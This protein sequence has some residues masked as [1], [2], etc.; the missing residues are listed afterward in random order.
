MSRRALS[1]LVTLMLAL[2][3]AAAAASFVSYGNDQIYIGAS[4]YPYEVGAD[5]R[6]IPVRI[7]ASIYRD[8]ENFYFAQESGYSEMTLKFAYQTQRGT[9]ASS[10]VAQVL[11]EP[12]YCNYD[13]VI[14]Y[15]DASRP[16]AVMAFNPQTMRKTVAYRSSYDI[17]A[18]VNSV[19]GLLVG[20]DGDFEL[21]DAGLK[22]LYSIYYDPSESSIRVFDDCHTQI[23]ADGALYVL[24]VGEDEPEYISSGVTAAWRY[25]DYIYYLRDYSSSARIYRF[26]L[27][28]GRS[29]TIARIY[30][31]L[32]PTLVAMDGAIYLSTDEG[33][34]LR[35]DIES[36]YTATVVYVD[37]GN[38]R[39]EPVD[40]YVIVYD[41]YSGEYIDIIDASEPVVVYETVQYGSRGDVVVRL[42]E[43]LRELGYLT[44]S[45]DGIFGTGTQRA[46][47]LLQFDMGYDDTGIATVEFQREIFESGAPEYNRYVSLRYGSSGIRV[48]ELNERLREL[49]YAKHDQLT[50][51]D[52]DTSEA[53]ER[54][55][56]QMGYRENGD[57]ITATQLRS[58]LSSSAPECDE[59][60]TLSRYDDAPVVKRLNRR[61]RTLGYLS[62]SH[63]NEKYSTY[64]VKAVKKFQEM[65][66]FTPDGVA[67]PDTQYELFSEF[68]P[69]PSPKPTP[70]PTPEPTYE[71]FPDPTPEPYEPVQVVKE[72]II[73]TMRT[74]MKNNL[75]G[76]Y[77]K[78]YA[79]FT[80]QSRLTELGYM[81]DEEINSV[82]DAATQSAVRQFQRDNGL[83][84]NGNANKK[85][86][87][88]MFLN[89]F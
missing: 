56:R 10:T 37:D 29:S 22:R 2:A 14:Y 55:Q 42:Q 75:G 24:Q 30:E 21:Y 89:E 9:M 73:N 65:V 72:S 49:Y 88:A 68:A 82:Y 44:S 28:D 11:F 50:D 25:D 5:R 53:V 1:I 12:V 54:F 86:L 74:W 23:T 45:A 78:D 63:V 39:L 43:K 7:A 34:I 46:V 62:A 17:E 4:G 51:Y 85:T 18:L 6:Y 79:V 47:R 48:E 57:V 66:Y 8:E 27:D 70:T 61:L 19:N 13:G 67:D 77:P 52:E 60:Y 64:T 31:N 83:N 84:D 87:A 76:S 38:V 33:E 35:Y 71:P 36:K 32:A 58:L 69:T 59:Y 3:P 20:Q 41:G 40:D 26:N 16:N 80:L 81:Y 15:V